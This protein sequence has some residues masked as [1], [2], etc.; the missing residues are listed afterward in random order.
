MRHLIYD[1]L[2]GFPKSAFLGISSGGYIAA[3][4][5]TKY[6]TSYPTLYGGV[7]T[8]LAPFPL[9]ILIDTSLVSYSFI[10]SGCIAIF[11]GIFAGTASPIIKSTLINVTYPSRRGIASSLHIICDDVGKG[12]GPYLISMLIGFFDGNRTHAFNYGFIGWMLCGFLIACISIYV[13]KDEQ[14]VLLL[15]QQQQA[16]SDSCIKDDQN[17]S[18]VES[19]TTNISSGCC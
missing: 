4:L 5:Y 2:C 16:L 8:F 14:K 10:A 18:N 7:M 12:L 13:E 17:D 19:N 9:Y 11:A 6:R 1:N 15:V 3:V